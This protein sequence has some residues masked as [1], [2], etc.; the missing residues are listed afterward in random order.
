MTGRADHGPFGIKGFLRRTD[1]G[2]VRSGQVDVVVVERLADDPGPGRR[3][4]GCDLAAL[5]GRLHER[6]DVGLE[7][8]RVTTLVMD[9]ALRD[10]CGL[11]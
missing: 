5:V 3:D 4:P 9:W 8:S 11:P 7:G 10:A 6:T 1:R 2:C